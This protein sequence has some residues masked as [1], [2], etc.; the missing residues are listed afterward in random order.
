M[1]STPMDGRKHSDEPV[2]PQQRKSG[3]GGGPT[4]SVK[5]QKKQSFQ[6]EIPQPPMKMR[7]TRSRTAAAAT[8]PPVVGGQESASAAGQKRRQAKRRGRR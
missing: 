3:P 8:V 1:V 6:I 7:T 4:A 2:A 5:W